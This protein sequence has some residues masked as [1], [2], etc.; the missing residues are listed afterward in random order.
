ME[1]GALWWLQFLRLFALNTPFGMPVKFTIGVTAY[2]GERLAQAWRM[3]PYD[4]VDAYG[5]AC[6][7][8]V[9]EDKLIA[10]E[11]L[12]PDPPKPPPRN[13]MTWSGQSSADPDPRSRYRR[14]E[15]GALELKKD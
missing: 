2:D 3:K 10:V 12:V 6:K 15:R 8:I 5:R 14:N 9:T 11:W 7:Q 1:E 13:P 4:V